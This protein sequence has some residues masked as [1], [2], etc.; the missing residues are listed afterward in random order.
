MTFQLGSEYTQTTR[1][2]K[3]AQAADLNVRRRQLVAAV[4]EGD[5]GR[6]GAQPLHLVR[7]WMAHAWQKRMTHCRITWSD[8]DALEHIMDDT[9]DGTT[10]RTTDGTLLLHLVRHRRHGDAEGAV[11]PLVPLLPR[12]AAADA[13]QHHQTQRRRPLKEVVVLVGVRVSGDKNP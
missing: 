5:D 13:R 3:G 4:E 9:M 7:R 11:A 2:S 8:T 10:D 1:T 12:V 6:V